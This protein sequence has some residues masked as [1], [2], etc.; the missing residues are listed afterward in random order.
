M[1]YDVGVCKRIGQIG[2]S[3]RVSRHQVG[4]L[5]QTGSIMLV[6]LILDVCGI[7][8]RD[9]SCIAVRQS[10]A[11]SERSGMLASVATNLQAYSARPGRNRDSITP[12]LGPLRVT[13]CSDRISGVGL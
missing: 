2:L 1:I 10:I 8:K 4:R 11:L 12:F 6:N 3:I 13:G 5:L 9:H 7:E